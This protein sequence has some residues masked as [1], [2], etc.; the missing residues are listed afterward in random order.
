MTKSVLHDTPTR[1]AERVALCRF[2]VGQAGHAAELLGFGW[3]GTAQ[4]PNS[5][6]LLIRAFDQSLMTGQP[7]PVSSRFCDNTMYWLPE[8][9]MAF[10]FWHDTTHIRLN[11]TFSTE[12][13]YEVANHH[14]HALERAGYAPS[15]VEYHLLHADTVGTTYCYAELERFPVHGLQFVLDCLEVGLV[16]AVALESV[17]SSDDKTDP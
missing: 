6:D 5:Y 8:T 2:I 4:A 13:E 3:V 10:R 17:R 7:L 11:R 9:N 14:L 16:E 15:S 1:E 12:D